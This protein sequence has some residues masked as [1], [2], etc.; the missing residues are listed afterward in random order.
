MCKRIFALVCFMCWMLNAPMAAI[1]DP[2]DMNKSVL[3]GDANINNMT[4]ASLNP[5]ID[6]AAKAQIVTNGGANSVGIIKWNSLNVGKGKTLDFNFTNANQVAFNNVLTGVSKFAGTVSSSGNKTGHV[7]IS[8]PNGIVVADGAAFKMPGGVTLT[9][10]DATSVAGANVAKGTNGSYNGINIGK[11]TFTTVGPVNIVSTGIKMNGTKIA[12]SDL[13][14]GGLYLYSADGVSFDPYRRASSGI[15]FA[16]AKGVTPTA[17]KYYKSDGSEL[18]ANSNAIEAKNVTVNN[19]VNFTAG[20]ENTSETNILFSTLKANCINNG[21]GMVSLKQNLTI[22]EKSV[23]GAGKNPD[24][25]LIITN[26]GKLIIDNS[27]INKFWF[28]DNVNNNAIIDIKNNS[29]V[30]SS[31]FYGADIFVDKSSLNNV[32]LTTLKDN[33]SISIANSNSRTKNSIVNSSIAARGLNSAFTIDAS[34]LKNTLAY[35]KGTTDIKSGSKILDTRVTAVD[36]KLTVDNSVISGKKGALIAYDDAEIELKNNSTVEKGAMVDLEGFRTKLHIKNSTLSGATIEILGPSAVIDAVDSYFVNSTIQDNAQGSKISITGGKTDPK[37]GTTTAV[38]NTKF[39]LGSASDL[40]LSG[41][42]KNTIYNK[43]TVN[44]LS[45][46]NFNPSTITLKEGVNA[47]GAKMTLNCAI[48]DIIASTIANSSF[49]AY[50]AKITSD[51]NSSIKNSKI[52]GNGSIANMSLGGTL[53]K[54][55]IT[56][57]GFGSKVTFN[58]AKLSNSKITMN[59]TLGAGDIISIIDSSVNKS[60]FLTKEEGA[61]V[62][63]FGAELN[64]TTITTTK[65][66]SDIIVTADSKLLGSTNLKSTLGTIDIYDSI[67][68]GKT[69]LSAHELIYIADSKSEG[70]KNVLTMNAANKGSS[71]D[72]EIYGLVYTG[73]VNLNGGSYSNVSMYNSEKTGSYSGFD[74]ANQVTSSFT[75][76]YNY[77]LSNHPEWPIA[78]EYLIS[79]LENDRAANKA[80][81]IITGNV[82]V[83]KGVGE[84]YMGNTKING[85]LNLAS[86]IGIAGIAYCDIKD[87]KVKELSWIDLYVYGRDNKTVLLYEQNA[88]KINGKPVDTRTIGGV[89]P[90][91]FEPD[92]VI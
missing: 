84:F 7:I 26:G 70:T 58:N 5:K 23:I 25:N 52:T 46:D 91:V 21:Q 75:E 45:Y 60:T 78:Y 24:S 74:T 28:D 51:T 72:F 65:F 11:A 81:T 6:T 88:G 68:S 71:P 31:R 82:N 19:R 83:G 64:N 55:T 4:N 86:S 12:S 41:A 56:A 59:N 43:L 33:G 18:A 13:L 8:N 69:T 87:V 2:I 77:L 50:Y 44:A 20:N 57:N 92:D 16:S 38:S 30:S 42:N 10:H 90:I 22:N 76:A 54:M 29:K 40:T 67:L 15:A 48:V 49:D 14:A 17:V 35:I 61:S 63:V 66:N 53:D 32:Y 47:T 73:N 27:T 34:D 36:G 79:T 62:F 3:G 85:T 89:E 80:P 39:N 9:T 1:A 37:K